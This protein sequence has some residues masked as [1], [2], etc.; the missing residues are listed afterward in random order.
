MR[1][2]LILKSWILEEF[3]DLSAPAPAVATDVIRLLKRLFGLQA[4]R[5]SSPAAPRRPSKSAALELWNEKLEYL[6]QQEAVVADPATKFALKKQIE[7]ARE[8]IGQLTV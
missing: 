3:E 6:Q 5:I 1:T 8:K 7:E 2:V 4:Q